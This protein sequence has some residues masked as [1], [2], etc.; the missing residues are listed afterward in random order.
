MKITTIGIDL[1]KS[2]FHV[3]GADEL[4][5]PVLKKRLSRKKLLPFLANITPCLVGMEACG[6]AHFWAREIKKLGHDVR[7]M[8]PQFVKPYVKTNKNDFNDAEGI[9]EA[10]GRANMRFVPIKSPAQQDLQAVHRIRAQLVK[11]RTA[12]GN[13]IRGLLAEYGIVI[14]KG[15]GRLRAELP[16]ILE[17][18]ENA[19]SMMAR[20]FI[21]DL[22]VRLSEL[23]DRIAQYDKEIQRAFKQNDAARRIE[24]V[25][26]VGPLVAT[27][28]VG[29]V[30]DAKE[31][32]NGRQLSA[33]LGLVPKQHST[34]GK[35]VLLGISKRGDTYIRTLLIHGARSVVS[36]VDRKEKDDPRSRWLRQLKARHG[37]NAAAV[38]LANKNARI[39]WALL[40]K[41]ETGR[42]QGTCRLN[43]SSKLLS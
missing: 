22:A 28:I 9:C 29:A 35:T 10:V 33:W 42:C 31:F 23:D 3:H 26:G 27:A 19:L 40:T 32:K 13:Q 14:P 38:A 1:A 36:Y 20:R 17:D 41:G 5:K 4:G 8:S 6:G 18:A 30:G 7:L 16:W 34:G 15:L 37:T 2:V 12:Q 25:E 21:A 39:I 24:Q 11:S 43:E